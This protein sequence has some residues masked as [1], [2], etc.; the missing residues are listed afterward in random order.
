MLYILHSTCVVV[1]LY[2]CIMY[3]YTRH[4]FDLSETNK[5]NV[6]PI[7][8]FFIHFIHHTSCVTLELLTPHVISLPFVTI[9]EL[10]LER[11]RTKQCIM[12]E[13]ILNIL[14]QEIFHLCPTCRHLCLSFSVV[15]LNESLKFFLIIYLWLQRWTT[16]Q[17][18]WFETF[19][20]G[21][22]EQYTH[23]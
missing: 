17:T 6:M 23:C 11:V 8:H 5:H 21:M 19:R 16:C 22:N 13:S 4:L 7:I 3:L 2:I 20:R 12:I 9:I 18:M 10:W 15:S 14:Q 1:L